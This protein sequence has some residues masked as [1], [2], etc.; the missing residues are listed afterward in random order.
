MIAPGNYGFDFIKKSFD[1]DLNN[2]VK[3]SNFVGQALDFAEKAGFKG[4]MLVGHI[5]K[6]VKLAGGIMNTHSKNADCRMEILA[7]NAA[8]V[9]DDLNLVRS[10]LNCCSTD[11]ALKLIIEKGVCERVMG[12]IVEKSIFYV[13][14]RLKRD[15][16]IGIVIFSNVYGVLGKSNGAEKM[17]KY[18]RQG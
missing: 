12:R 17:F 15:I 2:A 3:C 13:R 5:G 7:S 4:V 11:E 14:N 9:C 10:I 16:E 8:L 6:F 18:F 1:V